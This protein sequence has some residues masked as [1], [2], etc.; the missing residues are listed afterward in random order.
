MMYRLHQGE[1]VLTKK[2]NR[3]FAKGSGQNVIINMGGMTVREEADLDKIAS[4]LA[5]RIYLAGEAG[6]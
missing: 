1:R 4:K 5:R 2:E 3:Q 6:A